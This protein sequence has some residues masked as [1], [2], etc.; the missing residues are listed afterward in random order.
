MWDDE[1]KRASV[2]ERLKGL[3]RGTQPA[4]WPGSKLNTY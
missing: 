4:A 3:L 1:Q 2:Q